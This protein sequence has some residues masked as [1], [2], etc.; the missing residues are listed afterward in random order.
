MH[1]PDKNYVL[2]P[3]FL[4]QNCT[5]HTAVMCLVSAAVASEGWHNTSR[6]IGDIAE[7]QLTAYIGDS[8]G[9]VSIPYSYESSLYFMFEVY[10]IIHAAA[11]VG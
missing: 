6:E 7:V 2:K 9:G 8:F 4:L 3:F 1:T 10:N 11:T 5:I